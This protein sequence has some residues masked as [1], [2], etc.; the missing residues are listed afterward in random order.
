MTNFTKTD[1][2]RLAI[3]GKVLPD[4]AKKYASFKATTGE[5][6]MKVMSELE[7]F[8]NVQMFIAE[9]RSHGMNR[10]NMFGI[11]QPHLDLVA[12]LFKD[13]GEAENIFKH[14]RGVEA[15]KRDSA[16]KLVDLAYK[17]I[18]TIL[19]SKA[20]ISAALEINE[21]IRLAR[22]ASVMRQIISDLPDDGMT[23]EELNA[24]ISS[25]ERILLVSEHGE[26][27]KMPSRE[28]VLECIELYDNFI[29]I[30]CVQA[31]VNKTQDLTKDL[32][33]LGLGWMDDM[34]LLESD[35]W[36]F[37]FEPMIRQLSITIP[38]MLI[39]TALYLMNSYPSTDWEVMCLPINISERYDKAV[40]ALSVDSTATLKGNHKKI[41]EAV[42]TLLLIER[43][44]IKISESHQYKKIYLDSECS[45]SA[46]KPMIEFLKSEK[47][48]AK[49]DMTNSFI[50]VFY[51]NE[52][53]CDHLVGV[54]L[55]LE[56]ETDVDSD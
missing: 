50:S 26:D 4:S 32:S 47:D 9:S 34:V 55:A 35:G 29:K 27:D 1:Y 42:K 12:D 54:K 44:A 24:S 25:L 40:V 46:M 2:V 11:I 28:A 33:A 49:G 41:L 18:D 21:M 7:A 36:A 48:S 30:E 14:G 23:P 51:D 31:Q 16:I 19:R 38:N 15:R 39:K 20:A 10:I 5:I 17:L 52:T 37:I 45:D 56:G 3:A 13:G 22:D 53:T 6:N 8:I 43:D